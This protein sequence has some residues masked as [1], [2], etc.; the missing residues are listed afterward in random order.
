MWQTLAKITSH[1][2]HLSQQFVAQQ[3]KKRNTNKSE[4]PE[5]K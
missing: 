1:K 5:K 3:K 4:Y 2:P